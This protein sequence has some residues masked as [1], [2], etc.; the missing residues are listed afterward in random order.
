MDNNHHTHAGPAIPRIPLPTTANLNTVIT[1]I[2]THAP[3]RLQPLARG[4][5]WLR[6]HLDPLHLLEKAEAEARRRELEE[7]EDDEEMEME[8]ESVAMSPVARNKRGK[9]GIRVEDVVVPRQN[10]MTGE[11][12]SAEVSLEPVTLSTI[13]EGRSSLEILESATTRSSQ[14]GKKDGKMHRQPSGRKLGFAQGQQRRERKTSKPEGMS[15]T[16]GARQQS[17]SGGVMENQHSNK[18][19]D[20][21]QGQRKLPRQE[22]KDNNTTSS[23]PS[24]TMTSL[25]LKKSVD[26]AREQRA[27]REPEHIEVPTVSE[28]HT[29][30]SKVRPYPQEQARL[31]KDLAEALSTTNFKVWPVLPPLITDLSPSSST[32][33]S[34]EYRKTLTRSEQARKEEITEQWMMKEERSIE[35][36]R[37]WNEKGEYE[38]EVEK[39]ALRSTSMF[40]P[41]LAP[42]GKDGRGIP[43]REE[44]WEMI[45]REESGSGSS[46]E[47]VDAVESLG[48]PANPKE[49]SMG[50]EKVDKKPAQSRVPRRPTFKKGA[51]HGLDKA[52][53]PKDGEMKAQ[54]KGSS[55][56]IDA[57]SQLSPEL[58]DDEEIPKTE[59]KLDIADA[60]PARIWTG[61]RPAL[62]SIDDDPK[63]AG[64]T[65]TQK[66]RMKTIP[67]AKKDREMGKPQKKL[68]TSSYPPKKMPETRDSQNNVDKSS[69]PWHGRRPTLQYIDGDAEEMSLKKDI[70]TSLNNAS[71]TKSLGVKAKEKAKSLQQQLGTLPLALKDKNMPITQ[72]KQDNMNAK[73]AKSRLLTLQDINESEGTAFVPKQ[74][75]E[76]A[77]KTNEKDKT[78]NQKKQNN[79]DETK[80]R[81][82][83]R[84]MMQYIDND[85]EGPA[86]APPKSN[87]S[88][89]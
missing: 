68:E 19:L 48:T 67:Q 89:N 46:G 50:K 62:Q 53:R 47:Y 69:T 78:D 64:I 35:G 18:T 81:L 80:P 38:D 4:L 17:T 65:S 63:D 32:E 28:V 74:V 34:P 1:I 27:L 51:V 71:R 42:F 41:T 52:A 21:S 61:R 13:F 22:H 86:F 70:V 10:R 30:D 82:T 36:R 23:R 56:K 49:E 7:E 59:T 43:T 54:E 11:G 79:M 66:K 60:K 75:A 6:D 88:I 73:F 39:R 9:R 26:L 33:T 25:D 31:T 85:S 57:L 3:T 40:V 87:A 2:E 14:Q 5:T 45:D 84:L 29:L 15:E 58:S 76:I 8:M 83:R 72:T 77:T 55:L 20:P 37:T 24:Q 16:A 44:M 12:R